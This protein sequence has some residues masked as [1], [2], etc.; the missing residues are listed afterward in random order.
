MFEDSDRKNIFG[1]GLLGNGLV[2][3]FVR[4][5]FVEFDSVCI[6]VWGKLFFIFYGSRVSTS[7]KSFEDLSF[8]L[9]KV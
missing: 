4:G 8:L 6:Y 2:F 3:G 5:L 1:L 7:L 9:I